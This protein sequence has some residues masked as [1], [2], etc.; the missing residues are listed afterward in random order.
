MHTTRKIWHKRSMT[1]THLLRAGVIGAGAFGAN[2]VRKYAEH[3][4]VRLTAVYDRDLPRAQAVV[5]PYAAI[6]T[7]D[8]D[9]FFDAVDIVTVAAPAV[10]H[11]E[12]ALAALKAGKHVYVEKPLAATVAEADAILAAQCD[13]VLACGHQERAVFTAMGL[14]DIPERPISLDATRAGVWSGR[15]ADV[16][17]TLDLMVHDLDLCLA[18]GLDDLAIVSATGQRVHSASVD[19]I[20]AR[21]AAGSTVVT[22]TASRMASELSRHMTLVY[23]SGRVHID[24]VARAFENTTPFALNADFADTAAGRDPL[25]ASVG[26]FIAAVHTPGTRPLVTGSEARMALALALAADQTVHLAFEETVS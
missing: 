20:T 4:G 7:N 15:G 24:F 10:V 6:A 1:Q 21:Y 5:E 17:V 2:H 18:L 13:R 8:L 16:T 9:V 19:A 22:L 14:L 12:L 23:P 25:G 26:A 3:S 11:G